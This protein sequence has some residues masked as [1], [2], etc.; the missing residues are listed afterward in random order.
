[1]PSEYAKHCAEALDEMI[2]SAELRKDDTLAATL[3]EARLPLERH[4]RP[5][6][7]RPVVK[8]N[9]NTVDD[10]RDLRADCPGSDWRQRDEDRWDLR[11]GY[12]ETYVERDEDGQWIGRCDELMPDHARD[13][14]Y[15]ATPG[16]AA[17]A[18]RVDL[19][20]HV[21]SCRSVLAA[22]GEVE[23]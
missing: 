22:L 9:P 11:G 3:R 14:R 23:R 4:L 19:R 7:S 6:E 17:A 13:M 10:L 12:V 15:H 16:A 20:Y 1:M 2:R 18:L 5:V 21:E 8:S